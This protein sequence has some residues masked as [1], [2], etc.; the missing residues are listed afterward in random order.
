MRYL[1]H[2]IYSNIDAAAK[3]KDVAATRDIV[4]D[5]ISELI[6]TQPVKVMAALKDAGISMSVKPTNREFVNKIVNNLKLNNKLRKN[7]SALIV[8][9]NG[10]TVKSSANGQKEAPVSNAS[11]TVE[12]ALQTSASANITPENQLKTDL[13]NALSNKGQPISGANAGRNLLIFAVVVTGLIFLFK[14]PTQ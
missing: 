5:E 12:G 10:K 11:G 13:I 4:V 2:N 8:D 1:K 9:K 3:T 14:K 6:A 7:L